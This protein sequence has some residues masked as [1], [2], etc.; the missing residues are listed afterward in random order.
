MRTP[1]TIKYNNNMRRGPWPNGKLNITRRDRNLFFLLCAAPE[2]DGKGPPSMSPEAPFF[3]FDKR[4][5]LHVCMTP[6]A[7]ESFLTA[8]FI[9]GSGYSIYTIHFPDRA[10]ASAVCLG[11]HAARGDYG[12]CV[13]ARVS[14]L[15]SHAARGGRGGRSSV[16]TMRAQR[17]VQ[18]ALRKN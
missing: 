10:A 13:S 1:F 11:S 17:E 12:G 9:D 16:S 18:L 2:K 14:R 6:Q 7:R 5:C 3:L 8:F 4:D 15:D